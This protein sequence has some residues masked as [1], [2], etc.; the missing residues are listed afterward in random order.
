MHE[1][2]HRLRNPSSKNR[3]PPPLGALGLLVAAALLTACSAAGARPSASP[4]FPDGPSPSGPTVAGPA[5]ASPRQSPTQGALSAS[6]VIAHQVELD[7]TRITVAAGYWADGSIQLL[8]DVFMESYP[9]QVPRDQSLILRGK[10]PPTIL[11][12]LE[13]A[14]PGYADVTWGWVT[15]TGILRAG[16]ERVPPILE[17]ETIGVS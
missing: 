8:S 5:T 9:P 11:A 2:P 4:L 6:E 12:Q 1:A 7:G 15:V 16:S 3:F 14:G 17:L 13:R 10:V